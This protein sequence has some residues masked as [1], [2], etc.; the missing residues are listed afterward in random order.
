MTETERVTC[1]WGKLADVFDVVETAL[2]PRKPMSTV[3]IS[4]IK[5]MGV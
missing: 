2:V 5:P 1:Y 3:Y 4:A